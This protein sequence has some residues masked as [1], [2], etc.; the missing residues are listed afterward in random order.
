MYVV[1]V[2]KQTIQ[3]EGTLEN[4]GFRYKYNLMKGDNPDLT[5]SSKIL[6]VVD[7]A[8]NIPEN[9]FSKSLS[10]VST[11]A[12]VEVQVKFSNLKRTLFASLSGDVWLVS[13]KGIPEDEVIEAEGAREMYVAAKKAISRLP[14]NQ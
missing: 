2:T 11:D 6:A 4:L 14:V 9:A 3:K 10:E 1:T 8:K 5:G 7:S 13:E 12:G